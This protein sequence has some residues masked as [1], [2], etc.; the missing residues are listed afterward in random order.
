MLGISNIVN[1]FLSRYIIYTKILQ[2][3]NFDFLSFLGTDFNKF[4]RK[5]TDSSPYVD[6][7]IDY[8]TLDK[9]MDKGNKY[10]LSIN[11]IP[12]NSGT[13]SLVFEG[14]IV[15]E[16]INKKIAIKLLR[17]DIKRRIENCINTFDWLFSY[18]K[19]IPIL[20]AIDLDVL[21]NDVKENLLEQ[22][23][24]S[25]ESHYINLF[26]KRLNKHKSIKSIKLVPELTFDNVIVM[27]FIEGRS[28][29]KL[30]DEEKLEFADKITSTLFY[31]QIKKRLFHLDLH[32]GNILY[33][34]DNKI[35][36]LDLGMVMELDIGECNLILDFIELLHSEDVNS[37]LIR[38]FNDYKNVIFKSGTCSD[39]LIQKIIMK[40]PD[41]YMNKDNISFV[42]DTKFLLYELSL[43]GCKITKRVNQ[44]LFGII[45]FIN[46][47]VNLGENIHS[48]LIKNMKLYV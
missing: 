34:N 2:W 9:L 8:E 43:S 45:S 27:E 38:I 39:D 16:G 44:I 20:A 26:D 10:E 15:H 42:N 41:I 40:K 17:K 22:V 19:Y 4:L 47:F 35:T 28:I 37:I 6:G 30:R 25:K 3:V 11:R 21:F 13:I 46:I 31:C 48:V 14:N 18:M 12:I 36:Y 23:D 24:F 1:N 5:F 33:T 29:F 7:D 32:P